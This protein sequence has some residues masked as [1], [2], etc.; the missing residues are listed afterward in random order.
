M[1]AKCMQNPS[2]DKHKRCSSVC[3][4][5]A[6]LT[7][8]ISHVLSLGIQL[9][10]NDKPY[11]FNDRQQR[12]TV[13]LDD[14]NERH[15]KP[16]QWYNQDWFIVGLGV[17]HLVYIYRESEAAEWQYDADFSEQRV[18]LG[19]KIRGIQYLDIKFGEFVEC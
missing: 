16:V 1:A 8:R 2:N 9:R 12:W 11:D 17:A 14:G 3:F 4:R 6:I 7:R 10:F 15:L 5:V 13:Q 18:H 19:K